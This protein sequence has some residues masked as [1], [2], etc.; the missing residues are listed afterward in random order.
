MTAPAIF[1]ELT[2]QKYVSLS[3][4]RK[5]GEAVA[6]PVWFAIDGDRLFIV[7]Q[8]DSGKVKRIR[9]NPRVTMTP[10]DAQGKLVSGAATVEGLAVLTPLVVGE[11]GDRA[12]RAKYGWMYQ[13]FGFF[14]RL[15]RITA[16]LLEVR[17]A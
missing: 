17:S 6:T 4:F 10:S 2:G 13:A 5:S 8:D 7:T 9:N 11:R 14:W 15:R 3:T 16:V 12:L 1:P